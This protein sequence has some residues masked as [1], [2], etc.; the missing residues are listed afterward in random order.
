MTRLGEKALEVLR[1]GGSFRYGLEKTYTGEKF[2]ARLLTVEL[3][4]VKGVGM[5]TFLE[6]KEAGLLKLAGGGTTVSS[7][8][9]LAE[10]VK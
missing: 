4:K 5:K 6:L 7:Y 10:F 9:K 1:M 8:Y 2:T 3:R